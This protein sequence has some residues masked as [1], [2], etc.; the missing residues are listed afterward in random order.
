MPLVRIGP[1]GGLGLN[2]DLSSQALPAEAWTEARNVRFLD[3]M[4]LQFYGHG[5]V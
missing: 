2:G 1:A 5:E 4:A 3:G